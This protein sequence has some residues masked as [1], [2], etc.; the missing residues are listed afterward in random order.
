MTRGCCR[1]SSSHTSRI[2]ACIY[3][4]RGGEREESK[5]RVISTCPAPRK[6]PTVRLIHFE[7]SR[8][9]ARGAHGL[10]GERALY[11]IEREREESATGMYVCARWEGEGTGPIL[12]EQC[13]KKTANASTR[14]ISLL[15]LSV[16]YIIDDTPRGFTLSRSCACVC[17]YMLGERCGL[18]V[19]RSRG[20]S[21]FYLW[22]GARTMEG[23]CI[24]LMYANDR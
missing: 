24:G 23:E 18:A 1:T 12:A 19:V 21:L 11:S 5:S 15:A 13:K 22:R 7:V 16:Y 9:R 10:F 14:I 6:A 17:V 20:F 3:A 8:E 2:D 4:P